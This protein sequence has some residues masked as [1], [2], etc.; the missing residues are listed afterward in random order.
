MPVWLNHAPFDG[1][2]IAVALSKD[3][4]K[5]L[6]GRRWEESLGLQDSHTHTKRGNGLLKDGSASKRSAHPSPALAAAA[7]AAL[8]TETTIKTRISRLITRTNHG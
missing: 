4:G 3:A 2:T 5:E 7:P 6:Q 1:W 8:A